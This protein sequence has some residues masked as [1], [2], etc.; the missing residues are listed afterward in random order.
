MS[1]ESPPKRQFGTS[2]FGKLL[3]DIKQTCG[4]T[5]NFNEELQRDLPKR[6]EKHGDMVIL[7]QNCFR[8]VQWRL[9]GTIFASKK[10]SNFLLEP[11]FTLRPFP[12]GHCGSIVK[13]HARGTQEMYWRRSL[14]NSTH[15]TEIWQR[16]LGR[17][18]W[19]EYCVS[20]IHVRDKKFLGSY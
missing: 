4:K 8:N 9:L 13:R 7:P 20:V 2:A 18:S 5:I 16:W 17:A 3:D 12:L 15:R 11:H 1:R 6:W 10:I 14:Q 19:W